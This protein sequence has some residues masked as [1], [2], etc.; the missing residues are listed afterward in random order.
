MRKSHHPHGV[1]R[2]L[3]SWEAAE[4]AA[5]LLRLDPAARR[6]RFH[7]AVSD[8]LLAE[9]AAHALASGD[10]RVIGWFKDGVLRGAVEIAFYDA[11]AGREAEAAFAVEQHDRGHGVAGISSCAG[12]RGSR[13][14]A[15][16]AR[17]MSPLRP[18][19]AR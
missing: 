19:T 17:C 16:S 7:G 4:Y 13:G 18:R 1:Y 14:T 5:H 8:D 2:S 6:R 3:W 10:V 11:P 12:R 15:A 9:H